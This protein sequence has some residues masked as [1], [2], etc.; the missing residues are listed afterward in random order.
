VNFDEIFE[1]F[2]EFEEVVCVRE[3]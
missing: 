3:G 2:S 1:R